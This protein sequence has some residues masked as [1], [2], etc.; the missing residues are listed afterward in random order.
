MSYRFL[1][2][3]PVYRCSEGQF[4]KGLKKRVENY[5]EPWKLQFS[6]ESFQNLKERIDKSMRF[7]WRYNEIVGFIRV[8]YVCPYFPG[9]KIEGNLF[10]KEGKR[11]SSGSRGKIEYYSKIMEHRAH[12]CDSSEKIF[13]DIITDLEQVTKHQ[14][15]SRRFINTETIRA[16]GPFIN[17][18]RLVGL[19]EE[20]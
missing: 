15:F 1:F 11:L 16:I 8:S 9:V 17:W 20:E 2:D 19:E 5:I 10:L 14:V 18:R 3:V 13:N 12:P 6:E 4:E 7:S